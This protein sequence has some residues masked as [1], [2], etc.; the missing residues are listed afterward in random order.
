VLARAVSA[1][2]TSA[3]EANTARAARAIGPPARPRAVASTPNPTA[4][5]S[6][7]FREAVRAAPEGRQEDAHPD[8]K[9]RFWMDVRMVGGG[10]KPTKRIPLKDGYIGMRLPEGFFENDPRSIQVCWIDFYRN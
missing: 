2:S 5:A 10:G 4:V 6:V 3:A 1:V 8:A 7:P 9:G